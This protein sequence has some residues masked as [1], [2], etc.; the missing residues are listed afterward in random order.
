MSNQYWNIYKTFMWLQKWNT[1]CFIITMN[2]C[3]NAIHRNH[4]VFYQSICIFFSCLNSINNWS[5]PNSIYF[6]LLTVGK[7]MKSICKYWKGAS[8]SGRASCFTLVPMLFG[9]VPIRYLLISNIFMNICNAKLLFSNIYQ[10]SLGD[11]WN[12]MKMNRIFGECGTVA[13]LL[14]AWAP[15]AQL[16]SSQNVKSDWVVCD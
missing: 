13:A 11:I 5:M 9:L 6:K 15:G 3:A 4:F 7:R 10:P 2:H 1:V 14:S 16:C 8:G 12:T